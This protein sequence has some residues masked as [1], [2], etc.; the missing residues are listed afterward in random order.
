MFIGEVREDSA[1][2]EAVRAGMTGLVVTTKC[3]GRREG[4][5]REVRITIGRGRPASTTLSSTSN[6]PYPL[7][8]NHP[9]RC[10]LR[11]D[12]TSVQ[13]SLHPPLH[14]DHP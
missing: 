13:I 4:R 6:T 10:S 9:V 5:E 11:R 14:E 12:R 1:A 2:C 3:C 8:P 7:P